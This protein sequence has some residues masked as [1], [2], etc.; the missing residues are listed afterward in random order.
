MR[1]YLDTGRISIPKPS[2]PTP[3]SM[4]LASLEN[5]HDPDPNIRRTDSDSDRLDATRMGDAE[6]TAKSTIDSLYRTLA[7]SRVH[8]GTNYSSHSNVLLS[9]GVS[10]E[11][12]STWRDASPPSFVRPFL[13][14]LR[15]CHIRLCF[16]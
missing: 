2:A 13:T 1:H 14:L 10:E 3:A 7:T 15:L 12:S 9:D 16:S 11:I 8:E 5:A 6:S 4:S